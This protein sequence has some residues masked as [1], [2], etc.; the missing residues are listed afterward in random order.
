MAR[1][2]TRVAFVLLLAHLILLQASS[3]N[4]TQNGWQAMGPGGGGALFEPTV[5]SQDPNRVLVACDMTGSYLTKDGGQSWHT[6]N[7]RG[8]VRWFVFDPTSNDVIYARSIG[9]WRSKDGA[10]T[11]SLLYPDPTR[12]VGVEMSDDHAGE[13]FKTS[14][15]MGSITALAVDPSDSNLL[16][17]VLQRGQTSKVIRSSDQGKSWSDIATLSSPSQQLYI[18]PHSPVADRSLYV[19]AKNFLAVRQNGVW[20][21]G[22]PPD[23][24][25][26]FTQVSLGFPQQGAPVIVA[27]ANNSILVSRDGG[28][29]W[30]H[31]ELPGTY[32]RPNAIAVSPNHPE[33]AYVSYNGLKDGWLG[34][35][36]P[37]F[38]IARTAD[39]GKSWDLVWKESVQC[40]ANVHD[41][42]ISQS[43]GCNYAGTALGLAVSLSD[44][45]V[46]YATDEGR[47]LRTNDGGKSWYSIYSTQQ[48]DG[49]FSGRGLETTTSYGVHFDPFDSKRMFLSYTDIGLF[50]SENSGA[51]WNSSIAGVPPAWRNTTYWMAF[52]PDV[53]GRVWAVMS[54]TH[55]L[56]RPKMWLRKS[57]S[58][59]DGGVVLS[60][61]GGKTW[62]RSNEGMAPTAATHIL[63]DPRSRPGARTLYVAAFGQGV[64]KSVD[65]GKTWQLKNNG[66]AGAEPFAWRLSLASTGDLYVV[67]ARRS[68]DGGIGNEQD[69]AI[70]RSTDGA[71]HWNRLT[72]PHGVNGP[73]G[74]AIDPRDPARLYL[75]AWGRNTPPQTTDG[76]M[77]LSTDSGRTWRNTL[78]RDQ[79]IYDITVDPR[80]SKVVYAAGFESSIWRSADAG[81]TWQRIRGFNF[82]WSHR[83][84]PDPVN[85][86]QV[87]VT[88]FGGGVWHGPARGDPNSAAEIDLFPPARR[89]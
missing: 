10:R 54:K 78:S 40:A 79:H 50:R 86:T 80:D 77:F 32:A 28:T 18:D 62:R 24:V 16:Y 39:G 22:S 72:L 76:G 55:D 27:I 41:A 53:K 87:Y 21:N 38:G 70:Y 63:L 51:S 37:Q 73:N 67:I 34:T 13:S 68:D 58:E 42:W 7:L 11:W 17:A 6:F 74:L 8:R 44:P 20:R 89:K 48:P 35:G 46:V 12:V 57:P 25:N 71:E 47:I 14:E 88:T 66:I 29:S 52:D 30:Q 33:I 36:K 23:K 26:S 9:L 83:V 2:I 64:Y 82:K 49:T 61:D 45:N 31:S 59:Y 5:S 15:P 85:P 84:I 60:E 4:N 69:G 81:G 19:V 75:A 3:S 56:P 65:D 1:A 43:F